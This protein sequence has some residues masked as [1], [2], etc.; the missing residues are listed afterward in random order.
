MREAWEKRHFELAYQPQ[1]NILTGRV[2][3]FEALLRWP[4]P[5]RGNIP[6]LAFI[7]LAEESGLFDAIGQWVLESA[8][9]AAVHWPDDVRVAVNLSAIQLQNEALPTLVA[10]ALNA[11]GLAPARLELEIAETSVIPADAA[12]LEMLR[13]I[14]RT[15]VRIVIDDFDIGHSALSHLLNCPFDKLKIDRIFTAILGQAENRHQT[16][17]AIVRAI[18]GLCKDLHVTLLAEGVETIEQLMVLGR[19]HCTEIQGFLC[20]RPQSA[21][22][23]PGTLEHSPDLL[24]ELTARSAVELQAALALW[25]ENVPFSKIAELISDVVIVTTPDLAAPGPSIVYVNSAF[26]RLTGYTASEAIGQTPRI[27]QGPG[28]CRTTL[29]KISAKLRQGHPVHEK[30]LNFAKTGAPYWLDFQIL[31][32]RNEAG[33]IT[34]F[35]AIERDVTLDKRRLDELE[36]LADRDTLTGIPNRRA[37]L[38]AVKSQIEAAQQNVTSAHGKGPCLVYMDVDHFKK[39]NDELGHPI[40]DAVLCGLADRLAEN[41]RRIDTIGRIGGEEFAICMPAVSLENAIALADRLRSAVAAVPLATPAGPVNTTVSIGVA[42]FTDGDDV[43]TLAARA[44]AALYGAKRA[45]RN[46]VHA[47]TMS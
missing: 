27:L 14:R 22:T 44:D 29:D 25:S 5:T 13:S 21:S 9:F 7:P 10:A 35:V 42:C 41:V 33:I 43:D 24:R 26:T 36:Y 38:R 30:I 3:A 34:H 47:T 11:A 46:Q 18:A 20:G 28:T 40:G 37:F 31:P 2:V 6:P 1:F 45:G 12:C 23:I 32:L 19:A 4:H 16:A 17:G 8:C 15:G 39:V